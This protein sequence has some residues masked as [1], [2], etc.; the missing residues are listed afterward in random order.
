MC[1]CVCEVFSFFFFFKP[2]NPQ[3]V[4]FRME[5]RICMKLSAIHFKEIFLQQS[6]TM[7]M[8]ICDIVTQKKTVL[9]FII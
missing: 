4:Y 9:V 7:T 6:M 1:V 2:Q 5:V 3:C 8:Y